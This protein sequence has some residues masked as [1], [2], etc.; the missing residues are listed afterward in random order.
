MWN[1]LCA[2]CLCRAHSSSLL[3]KGQQLTLFLEF[4]HSTQTS[5]IATTDV[6]A[7]NPNTGHR[8]A[9][10]SVPQFRS[11]RF[12]LGHD[13]QLHHF[14]LCPDL[15]ENVL[16]P[17]AKGTRCERVHRDRRTAFKLL[18]LPL[19]L[20]R[21]IISCQLL[22]QPLFALSKGANLADFRQFLRRGRRICPFL[23][24]PTVSVRTLDTGRLHPLHLCGLDGLGHHLPHGLRGRTLPSNGSRRD[25]RHAQMLYEGLFAP[26]GNVRPVARQ[27]RIE[28]PGDD[29]VH[30]C[31]KTGSIADHE[32]LVEGQVH[33]IHAPLP[34]PRAGGRVDGIV[35][36]EVG[37]NQ[38]FG[39]EVHEDDLIEEWGASEGVVLAVHVRDQQIAC[40][41]LRHR[42]ADS[43][44]GLK[45][46]LGELFLGAGAPVR[47]GIGVRIDPL[48]GV[49]HVLVVR[50]HD[51][52]DWPQRREGCLE[53]G[54]QLHR[55]MNPKAA[56]R[57]PHDGHL[58]S[59]IDRVPNER[60]LSH[61]KVWGYFLQHLF[62]G[63]GP[64]T[65]GN[66]SRG[67][68]ARGLRGHAVEGGQRPGDGEQCTCDP[69][70]G[71]QG[72]GCSDRKRGSRALKNAGLSGP[73]RRSWCILQRRIS[74]ASDVEVWGPS[75]SGHGH[76]S[77]D[78]NRL[79]RRACIE[80]CSWGPGTGFEN[81]H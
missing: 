44:F 4:G 9:P 32:L 48:L 46:D 22:G 1:G 47:N 72:Q 39:R 78:R 67:A 15:V 65:G 12:A 73:K 2:S 6:L 70:L 52:L 57:Q 26:L 53:R 30:R 59:H 17:F 40:P 55:G 38:R 8:R 37:H 49:L 20:L 18:H 51:V 71:P 54:V 56:I 58:P 62:A 75:S 16:R 21:V 77:V 68:D 64:F 80:R 27:H 63:V 28:V 36:E 81:C 34:C 14:V 33:L 25:R 13:V 76:R 50:R 10:R 7:L 60:P 23:R 69:P 31:L 66:P 74:P 45:R 35:P 43:H 61:P 11:D 79:C 41:C 24:L 42:V 19:H 29:A 3:Q 5:I